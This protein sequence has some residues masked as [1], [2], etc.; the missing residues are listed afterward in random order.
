MS[1]PK[2][3][4]STTAVI[5]MRIAG[6]AEACCKLTAA[7]PLDKQQQLQ[8]SS[9]AGE[10]R[11]NCGNCLPHEQAA[12]PSGIQRFR[13]R[14]LARRRARPSANGHVRSVTLIEGGKI[15][16]ASNT[17]ELPLTDFEAVVF[18]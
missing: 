10:L 2:S 16:T 18:L 12:K 11:L 13:E 7:A 4:K 1:A 15:T 14:S 8:H 3:T 9:I 5:D 6:A 17:A